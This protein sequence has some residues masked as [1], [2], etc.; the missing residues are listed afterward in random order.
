MAPAS[1]QASYEHTTRVLQSLRRIVVCIPL[2]SIGHLANAA[3]AQVEQT[4]PHTCYFPP[5]SPSSFLCGLYGVLKL[6]RRVCSYMYSKGTRAG[7]LLD[8][9]RRWRLVG[10]VG[11]RGASGPDLGGPPAGLSEV[12]TVKILPH[13]WCGH[14]AGRGQALPDRISLPMHMHFRRLN[15]RG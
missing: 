7:T 15:R 9:A 4:S 11:G 10:A 1:A 8:R 12:L 6:P 2:I 14:R 5:T 13:H 3:A